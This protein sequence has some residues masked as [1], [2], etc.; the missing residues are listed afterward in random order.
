MC[1][2]V[3]STIRQDIIDEVL[4]GAKVVDEPVEKTTV[5]KKEVS[6]P[7]EY[8]TDF[9]AIKTSQVRAY[10]H[11]DDAISEEDLPTFVN[12]FENNTYSITPQ[13]YSD[14]LSLGI[15]DEEQQGSLV[16]VYA[17]GEIS[18]IPIDELLEKEQWMPT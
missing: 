5:Q 7:Y 1:A 10:R 14:C 4:E 3:G 12:I 8:S 15:Y 18:R 11:R 17:T 6:R 13:L 16:V 2:R 9:E